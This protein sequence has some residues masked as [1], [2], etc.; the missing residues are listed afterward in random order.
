M[1]DIIF[2][3]PNSK[4]VGKYYKSNNPTTPIVLILYPESKDNKI[5]KA[6][7]SV[8]SVLTQE[9]FSVFLFNFTKISSKI[10]DQ[11]Q[12]KEEEILEV[13]AALNWI[14]KKHTEG[15][16]LW[17]FS[18]FSACSVG[19]QIVMRRPEISD[20]IL[21]SPSIK[22]KDFSFIVPCS[23]A[24]LIVY[25]SNLPN[26]IDEMVEKLLNKSD[27]KV[28]VIPLDNLNLEKGENVE[29]MDEPL[30]GYIKKRL[31]EDSGKIK[32]IKRDRR[33]RKKKKIVVEEDKNV[34]I[35]PIKSLEFD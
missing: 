18:F 6:V 15:R 31:A 11:S 7:E 32:K 19:L 25:E 34:H 1:T 14:N 26:F 9:N 2:K 16:I 21:F 4:L 13:I 29:A 3:G 12:K 27:S 20:Y 24:G 23:A 30:L 35:A 10:I 5:P 17:L 8:V 28:E 33:R 22:I